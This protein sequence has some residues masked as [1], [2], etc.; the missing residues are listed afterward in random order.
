[1]SDKIIYGKGNRIAAVP[2]RSVFWG[3]TFIITALCLVGFIIATGFGSGMR[4]SIESALNDGTAGYPPPGTAKAAILGL[5][6]SG[7]IYVAL[8]LL[9]MYRLTGWRRVLST[10]L[11]VISIFATTEISARIF[12]KSHLPMHRPHPIFLWELY[13][14]F[15]GKGETDWGPC[16]IRIN[17]YGFRGDEITKKKPAETYR[18]M[19]LGDSA[20]FG[21][22]VDQG[23]EFP[24]RLQMLLS[25]KYQGKSIQVL[26]AA[27]MGYTTYSSRAYFREKGIRFDPDL[28]ILAQNNDGERDQEEDKIRAPSPAV[29]PLYASEVYLVIRKIIQC[30][31][32]D[33]FP[34]KKNLKKRVAPEDLR[35]N[36]DAILGLCKEKGIKAIVVSMPRR[37]AEEESL[38]S[39]RKI[40][41]EETLKFDGIFVDMIEQW[42]G[43]E[44]WFPMMDE[45]HPAAQGHVLIARELAEV[46]SQQKLIT[47]AKQERPKQ[48]DK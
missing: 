15:Q 43:G 33:R 28:V 3:V 35:A 44:G 48:I 40:M 1:M 14:G 29:R 17:S 45:M 41:K 11:S 34:L 7:A 37:S 10:L 13:P 30:S 32:A 18:I 8:E 25:E 38:Q 9:W 21:Y 47:D 39:Y 23:E 22:G 24:A 6:A 2:G 42:S 27:V 36:L 46:I 26:N 31:E 4:T 20:A 19:V 5:L 12:I 16:R